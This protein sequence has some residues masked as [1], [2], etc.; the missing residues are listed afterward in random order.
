[1]LRRNCQTIPQKFM[2]LKEI[3]WLER[4]GTERGALG[5]PIWLDHQPRARSRSSTTWLVGGATYFRLDNSMQQCACKPEG[6]K[7][8]FGTLY[9][10]TN[11]YRFALLYVTTE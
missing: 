6:C 1:M 11:W 9:L 3:L 10:V 2:M 4:S 7:N 5:D 8:A